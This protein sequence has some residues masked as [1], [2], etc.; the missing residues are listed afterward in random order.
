MRVAV[1]TLGCKVNQVESA[2]LVEAFEAR[3][4]RIVPFNERA[5]LYVVNTCAVTAKAAYQS[6]QLIRRAHRQAPAARVVATGCYVQIAPFEI[7]ERSLGSICLVGNDQKINLVDLALGEQG[8]LDI[9]VGDVRRIQKI[10]PFFVR[11][12]RGRTRAFLRVQDGC[13]AFCSYCIVPYSRGPSRSLP[14]REV[15]RQVQAFLEEGYREIVVTGI[16]LGHYGQ[17]LNPRLDL[18]DLL[19]EIEALGPERIR[20]S[21][22]EVREISERFLSWA[23]AS[24]SLSPHFHIPL[25]SGDDRILQ[26]MN[27]HYTAEEYLERIRLLRALFPRAALGADVLVGFPGEGPQEFENTYRL[28]EKSPLSY[29]H[30][31]PFSPRPGTLAEAMT[32][33]VSPIELAERL[34]RLRDLALRKRRSFYQ[35]QLGEVVS[36][37]VE[38]HDRETGL[39][40]GTSENYLTVLIEGEFPPGEIIPVKIERIIGQKALGRPL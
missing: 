28:V 3:G 34:K 27:R 19:E 1:T 18:V 39:K 37:L 12:L 10:A 35:C 24:K 7:I 33:R 8:C 31:F 20:L 17:D 38:G 2:S 23:Q 6:R 16:H 5:D 36:V 15:R 14:L 40:R 13:N 9:Y 26:A 30:V 32:P 25:Q 11:R 22:L 4:A 29:L 21:S